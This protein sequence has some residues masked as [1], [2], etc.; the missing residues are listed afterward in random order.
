MSMSPRRTRKL[1]SLLAFLQCPGAFFLSQT[2]SGISRPTVC[3]SRRASLFS[4]LAGAA[5]L[6]RASLASPPLCST[7]PAPTPDCLGA[8]DGLLADCR[9]ACVSSQDDRPGVFGAPWQIE[10]PTEGVLDRLIVACQ[11]RKDFKEVLDYDPAA[12]YLRVTF[13]DGDVEFLK[14][15]G[16]DTIQFRAASEVPGASNKRQKKRVDELRLAMGCTE[17]PVLRNRRRTLLFVESDL[18]SFGPS[19]TRDPTPEEIRDSD[20]LSRQWMPPEKFEDG[21]R[22]RSE[23]SRFLIQ[24][25][26]DR[27]RSK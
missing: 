16:D 8:V 13:V 9:G 19:S 3:A 22:L 23:F 25:A 6:S 11:S 2:P 26:D 4:I 1:V 21:S 18:D 14:T 12:A 24:E 20:P 17:I 7:L 10:G 5:C 15:R 27:V